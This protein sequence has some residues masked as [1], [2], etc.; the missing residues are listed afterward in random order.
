MPLHSDT[1][2]IT[3]SYPEG[4][5]T[6]SLA[7]HL[8]W[9]LTLCTPSSSPPS[10]GSQLVFDSEEW[11][12]LADSQSLIIANWGIQNGVHHV[13]HPGCLSHT[14]WLILLHHLPST[15]NYFVFS[16]RCASLRL[17]L[18]LAFL[19][20]LQVVGTPSLKDADPVHRRTDH[21]DSVLLIQPSFLGSQPHPPPEVPSPVIFL[22][23]LALFWN[24]VPTL[25][26]PYY[27]PGH[28]SLLVSEYYGLQTTNR[29]VYRTKDTGNVSG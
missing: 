8:F 4:R 21:L 5:L 23:P 17:S 24:H 10:P 16:I 25:G 22:V 27:L 29:K 19:T 1:I 7:L 9:W 2:I 15:H 28:L 14:S 6:T 13:S 20:Q 12:Y 26:I 18:D 11:G 3:C